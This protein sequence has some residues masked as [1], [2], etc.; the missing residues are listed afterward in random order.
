MLAYLDFEK[1]LV[2]LNK[3]IY[4]LREYSTESVDFSSEFKK[5]EAK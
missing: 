1:P 5:L 3:K 4:E 2:D